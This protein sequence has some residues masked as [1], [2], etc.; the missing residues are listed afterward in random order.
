MT[1]TE[2][3]WFGIILG[4]LFLF[5]VCIRYS[6]RDNSVVYCMQKVCSA[7][8]TAW[9]YGPDRVN[10]ITGKSVGRGSDFACYCV[11]IAGDEPK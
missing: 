4:F 3:V 5:V 11:V 8:F 2:R 9:S 10:P 7:G 1:G 6:I